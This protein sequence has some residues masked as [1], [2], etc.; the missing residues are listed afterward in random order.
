MYGQTEA[1]PRM[2]YYELT[3]YPKKIG[4][5]G[6]PIKGTKFEI[7]KKELIF[8]GKNVSLGYATNFKDLKKNDIN[9][10][11]I[12]TGDIGFLDKDGFYYLTGRKKKIS[13]IFGLRI[14]LKDIENTLN[15][16]NYN[17]KALVD[18]K[19]IKIQSYKACQPDKIKEI[20]FKKY[21]INKNFIEI[22]IKENLKGRIISKI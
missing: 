11:K 20:I 2:S 8:H 22:I 10:G 16:K 4:S 7:L 21:K 12:H 14:D 17:V 9:K 18:D 1:S 13:K 3:K 6:K 5:I 19:K 15:Q